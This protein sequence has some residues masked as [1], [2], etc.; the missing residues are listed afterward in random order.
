LEIYSPN[1][2]K[3]GVSEGEFPEEL[4]GYYDYFQKMSQRTQIFNDHWRMMRLAREVGDCTRMC[5][6][7]CN[8]QAIYLVI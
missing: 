5:C 2:E 7:K 6:S 1:L 8:I 3:K 4:L